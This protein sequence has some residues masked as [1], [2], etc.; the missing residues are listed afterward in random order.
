MNNQQQNH[1]TKSKLTLDKRIIA[2]FQPGRRGE[3]KYYNI[4]VA[5]RTPKTKRLITI[6][7]A[8]GDL[9]LC[10]KHARAYLGEI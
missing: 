1:T 3:A 6:R 5:C 7:R 10:R 4:C 8:S 2:T 9:H